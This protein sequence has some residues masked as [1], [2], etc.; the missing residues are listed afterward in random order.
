LFSHDASPA[1]DDLLSQRLD[2]SMNTQ[3]PT[4]VIIRNNLRFLVPMIVVPLI[5]GCQ[6]K[7]SETAHSPSKAPSTESAPTQPASAPQGLKVQA[8]LVEIPGAFPANDLYNYV[9]IMRYE[10][11]QVLEG[12]YP[13]KDILVGQYNPRLSR[14]DIKD[15][16]DSMV[17]GNASTFEE[18]A[19]QELTLAPMDSLYHGAVEDEFFQ[20]KRGRW[21]AKRTDKN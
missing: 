6:K 14:A 10:V 20:D 18:G 12:V 11:V 5:L 17:D 2:N 7:D 21:F 19:M 16:L 3:A 1:F 4:S 8:K 15:E 13:D 9:Y